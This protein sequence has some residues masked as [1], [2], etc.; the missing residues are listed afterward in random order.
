VADGIIDVFKVAGLDKP[1]ISILSDQFLAE[2]CKNPQKNL[3]VE[4]LQRLLKKET[5][6]RFKSNAVNKCDSVICC[7]PHSITMPT[8]R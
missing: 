2:V 4:L 5:Q 1:D 6:T 3:A 8:V 7:S